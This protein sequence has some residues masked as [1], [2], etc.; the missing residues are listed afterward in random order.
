MLQR[1]R[2]AEHVCMAS[3]VFSD[4]H[5]AGENELDFIRVCGRELV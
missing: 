3:R 5:A 1:T 2:C 4:V